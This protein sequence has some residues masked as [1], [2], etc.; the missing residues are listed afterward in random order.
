MFKQEGDLE[1]LFPDPSTID[2][3][4]SYGAWLRRLDIEREFI[5][6]SGTWVGWGLGHG[7]RGYT[8]QDF[9]NDVESV[10][11]RSFHLQMGTGPT[12]IGEVVEPAEGFY[13]LEP[14]VLSGTSKTSAWQ[15]VGAK[16]TRGPVW[17]DP[18]WFQ[19]ELSAA[20]ARGYSVYLDETKT[21]WTDSQPLLLA[22]S[23]WSRAAGSLIFLDESRAL[24]FCTTEHEVKE[25]E[26]FNLAKF[27]RG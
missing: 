21:C 2:V 6:L 9:L 13:F 16:D 26:S 14:S 20:E 27:F 15:V 25:K 11:H 4:A 19:D 24:R 7:L 5:D 10:S 3:E 17:V 23:P 1:S 22:S 8:W 12:F 18:D